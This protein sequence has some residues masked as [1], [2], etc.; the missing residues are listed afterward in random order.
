M[1]PNFCPET[2][3]K[4]AGGRVRT[5]D[6][7]TRRLALNPLLHGRLTLNKSYLCFYQYLEKEQMESNFNHETPLWLR[8]VQRPIPNR[9]SLSCAKTELPLK[10][11]TAPHCP[12]KLDSGTIVTRSFLFALFVLFHFFFLFLRIVYKGSR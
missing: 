9:C 11:C 8:V 6:L 1:S 10:S 3:S 12:L 4:V 2:F 5:P 7:Q